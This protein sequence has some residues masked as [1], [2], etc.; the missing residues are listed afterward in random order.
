MK[1]L[2][3]PSPSV[4]RD[5]LLTMRHYVYRHFDAEGRPLYVGCS[6]DVEARFKQHMFD[7]TYWATKVA[8]TKITVHPGRNAGWEIEQQEIT[9]LE[10]LHNSEIYL[11]DCSQW[12]QQKFLEHGYALALDQI[13]PTVNKR[14]GLGRLH[15]YYAQI[16]D[17][18]L[19]IDLGPVPLGERRSRRDLELAFRDLRIEQPLEE[20]LERTG[21]LSA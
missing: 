4:S 18:D 12:G 6:K 21:G 7:S 5:Y 2:F 14:S 8:K 20:L 11:M 15:G 17:R 16:F 13:N 9:H 1:Q 10:P 19:F 3:K